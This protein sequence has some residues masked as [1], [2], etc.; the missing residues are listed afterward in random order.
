MDE[1]KSWTSYNF[2]ICFPRAPWQ[3]WRCQKQPKCITRSNNYVTLFQYFP[4][5]KPS[6]FLQGTASKNIHFSLGCCFL[7]YEDL[8][9]RR[10]HCTGISTSPPGVEE[11]ES[12]KIELMWALDRAASIVCAK[13]R[14]LL[15]VTIAVCLICVLSISS[16]HAD[17]TT[18]ASSLYQAHQNIRIKLLFSFLKGALP[19]IKVY[20]TFIQSLL[21]FYLFS[22]QAE[23]AGDV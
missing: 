7:I 2:S 14:S 22:P 13:I 15:T 3:P 10:H 6:M 19:L 17:G 16:C 8:F 21:E 1:V 9:M 5:M 20:L 4:L 12:H 18:P 23:C 11:D